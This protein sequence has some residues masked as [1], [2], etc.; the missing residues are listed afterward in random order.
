[1]PPNWILPAR[2]STTT[3]SSADV[4]SYVSFRDVTWFCPGNICL[5]TLAIIAGIAVV[6]TVYV[7]WKAFIRTQKPAWRRSN[8]RLSRCE[9]AEMASIDILD[10]LQPNF[11][12]TKTQ[13]MISEKMDMER[14]LKFN[15]EY[16]VDNGV[17]WSDVVGDMAGLGAEV[18]T[19]YQLCEEGESRVTV[20]GLEVIEE[21]E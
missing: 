19:E 15:P 18:A 14:E 10:I 5:I 17:N 9:H 3:L 21:E 1:M 12:Q 7:L 4:T 8:R 2:T 13:A 16:C 11:Q 6:V 20:W